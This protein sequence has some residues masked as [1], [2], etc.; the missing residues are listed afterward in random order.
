[1]AVVRLVVGILVVT[2]LPM[3]IAF[4]VIGA[5]ADEIDRGTPE[6]LLGIGVAFTALGCLLA[7]VFLLLGRR[8]AAR[9]KR[10]EAGLQATAEVV[11]AGWN[12]GGRTRGRVAVDLTVRIPGAGEARRTLFLPPTTTLEP[13]TPLAVRYDPAEPSNFEPVG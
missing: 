13:G 6:G 8:E 7:A 9:R 5:T 10:R 3:G 4:T 12:P 1:M 2:F 11:R